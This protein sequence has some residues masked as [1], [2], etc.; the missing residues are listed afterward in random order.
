MTAMLSDRR[1]RALA[2]AATGQV[3][4]QRQ[5]NLWFPLT[6]ILVLLLPLAVLSLPLVEAVILAGRIDPRA[7]GAILRTVLALSGT[8]IDIDS[9]RAR[10]RV[11]IF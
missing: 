11:R 2:P 9:P 4:R 6:P 1:P 3:R 8:D 7:V 10:V 5:L